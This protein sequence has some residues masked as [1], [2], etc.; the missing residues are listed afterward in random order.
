MTRVERVYY[1]P[2]AWAA[3]QVVC[4]IIC[5]A[6]YCDA[7]IHISIRKPITFLTR[8]LACQASANALKKSPSSKTNILEATF[9]IHSYYLEVLG[10]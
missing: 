9:P 8:L 10:G 5:V 6:V 4:I 3:K 7:C 1:I 2:E